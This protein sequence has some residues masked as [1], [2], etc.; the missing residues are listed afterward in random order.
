MFI[1]CAAAALRFGRAEREWASQE[2]TNGLDEEEEEKDNYDDDVDDDSTA[3][4]P[5]T[6]GEDGK[7]SAGVLARI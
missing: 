4:Y 2:W 3:I 1:A 5:A 6:W 7:D